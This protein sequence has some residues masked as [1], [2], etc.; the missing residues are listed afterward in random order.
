[1]AIHYH[2]ERLAKALLARPDIDV[3][4]GSTYHNATALMYCATTD[5][6]NDVTRH[7]LA[8]PDIDVNLV[9]GDGDTALH[10]EVQNMP[11]AD[12]TELLLQHPDVKVSVGKA[13][14]DPFLSSLFN[15]GQY[16]EQG[17]QDPATFRCGG[18][19][20]RYSGLAVGQK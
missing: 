12:F 19:A 20:R 10:W 1:M 7:L 16:K 11:T 3:N 9:D 5:Y 8:R 6:M 18:G 15:L 2:N 17:W 14:S 4:Q 13:I